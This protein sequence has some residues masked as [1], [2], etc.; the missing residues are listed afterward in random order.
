MATKLEKYT[1]LIRGLLPKGFAWEQVRLHGLWTGVAK[2]FSRVDDS[3]ES[4][5]RDIFPQ[6]TID[7]L[8]DWKK[9]VDV[10]D[11]CTPSGL[12]DDEAREQIVQKLSVIG[13]LSASVYEKIALDYGV[14]TTAGLSGVFR[15]G[16]GR[17]GDR[18]QG[19]AWLF[20][21]TLELPIGGVNNE[22]I[23]CTI[24]KLK[25]AHTT[26]TFTYA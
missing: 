24:I 20:D 25:P 7:L 17:C 8:S 11:E 14:T 10:P 2:E 16:A 22:I 6:D 12:T 26:V 23:E 1:E 21:F 18:L 13:S 15:T 3:A 4:L 9:T 5:L 19:V